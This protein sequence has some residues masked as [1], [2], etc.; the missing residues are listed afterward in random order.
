MYAPMTTTKLQAPV[1]VQERTKFD[2]V[3]HVR[4]HPTVPL[5]REIGVKL[6]HK[7]TLYT[8][9]QSKKA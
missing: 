1:L 9:N 2:R 4:E 8:K 5:V 6:K 7:N 3:T